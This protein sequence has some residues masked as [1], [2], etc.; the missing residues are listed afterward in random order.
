MKLENIEEIFTNQRMNSLEMRSSNCKDRIQ[1]L[2]LLLNWILKNRSNIQ[3]VLFK[4]LG[5]SP[6]ESD[7]TEI[8]T[9]TAELRYVI[10][11]LSKSQKINNFYS[12]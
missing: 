11:N 3:E 10:E 4:D 1:K 6:E 12:Q 9:L 2:K 5:K 7:I 8:Y